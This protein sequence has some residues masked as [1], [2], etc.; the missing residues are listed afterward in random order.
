MP[1]VGGE[2]S[3][4]GTARILAFLRELDVELEHPVQ[5]TIVGG[6]AIGLFYDPTYTT[7]DIDVHHSRDESFWQAVAR[8]SARVADPIP[9]QIPGVLEAPYDWEDRRETK[10]IPGLH[11]LAVLI[12]ERHDLALMKTTRG[13]TH[14]LDAVESMH[15]LAAFDLETLV[16]RY[17]DTRLQKKTGNEADFRTSFVVLIDRLFG[18]VQAARIEQRLL[19]RPP[20]PIGSV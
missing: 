9:I 14:D 4:F 2:I 1:P 19:T 8:A 17:Y 18:S 5:I 7:V 10:V 3:R 11:C 6:A 13:S 12:P 16:E 20:P 15:R